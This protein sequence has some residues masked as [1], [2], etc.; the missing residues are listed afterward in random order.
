MDESNFEEIQDL[1]L[2]IPWDGS[3][4]KVHVYLE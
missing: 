3:E 2:Q 4:D 1:E